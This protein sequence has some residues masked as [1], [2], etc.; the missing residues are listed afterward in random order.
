MR[1]SEAT[2]K[3][4]CLILDIV[5]NYTMGVV[6]SPSLFGLDPTILIQ[7][8]VTYCWTFNFTIKASNWK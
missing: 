4:N 5:G 8:N 2:G 1:L 6:N 3:E 7:G